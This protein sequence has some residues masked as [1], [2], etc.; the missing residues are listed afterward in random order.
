MAQKP[1]PDASEPTS[2]SVV[3]AR[4]G[5]TPK[6][7]A[8]LPMP[9]SAKPAVVETVQGVDLSGKPKAVF[10]IGRGR[11]GKTT[12][13][14]WWAEMMDERGGTALV[15]AADPINRSLRMFRDNVVEPE[16]SD[17]EEVKDWL[18]D[19]LQ[20]VMDNKL[21]A[22]IDL[23]GGSTT[24]SSVLQEMPDLA[25][26][27]SRHG[28][29]P[30]AVHVVGADPHDLVPLAMTEAA[31]FRPAAT[32]IVCNERDATRRRFD[33]I[34]QH[35][36]FL[37]AV[38]RG[39]VP[40]WMPRLNPDAVEQCDSSHWRYHDVRTKAG[41]F[42]ASAVQTWLRQMNEQFSGVMTWIPGS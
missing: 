2:S 31:G 41:P 27:L 11:V 37:A 32:A 4:F 23:G 38:E 30:V 21:N 12:T 7:P 14:R 15:A 8:I 29:E 26:V 18:R 20:H 10:F 36:T 19:L 6:P 33:Q 42:V 1:K 3:F 5:R 22:L 40:L 25:D 28:V 16:S 35:P 17:P 34:L 9:P 13:V 39:A 24:L